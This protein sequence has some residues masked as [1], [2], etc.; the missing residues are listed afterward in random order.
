MK[1]VAHFDSITER[2]TAALEAGCDMILVCND[3]Q[4]VDE[5][6]NTLEWNISATSLARLAR[7]HGKKRFT[8]MIT[9]REDGDYIQ[10]VRDIS[11]IDDPKAI[12]P[13]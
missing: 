1:G 7:M 9:L 13:F 6:L 4:A 2:A 11:V 10:A 8:S 3:T 5:L 12:L